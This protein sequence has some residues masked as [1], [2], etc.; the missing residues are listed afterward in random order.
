VPPSSTAYRLCFFRFRH[1]RRYFRDSRMICTINDAIRIVSSMLAPSFGS[2]S[3]IYLYS[4]GCEK[5][6]TGCVMWWPL[7]IWKWRK[8]R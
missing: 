4:I 6:G 5:S 3:F 1:S 2:W 8:S 7:L